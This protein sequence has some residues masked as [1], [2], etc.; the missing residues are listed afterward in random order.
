MISVTAV[1]IRASRVR[2]ATALRMR[3]ATPF[4][5]SVTR[6]VTLI[7]ADEDVY[8]FTSDVSDYNA[9]DYDL[10]AVRTNVDLYGIRMDLYYARRRRIYV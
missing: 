2:A 8:A 3:L 9:F 10:S 4:V 6:E 7:L 5:T 1:A